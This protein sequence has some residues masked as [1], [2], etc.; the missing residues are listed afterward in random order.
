MTVTFPS[1]LAGLLSTVVALALMVGSGCRDPSSA[2]F[3]DPAGS[4]N[5]PKTQAVKTALGHV[6]TEEV[7]TENFAVAWPGDTRRPI[8]FRTAKPEQVA[9][10]A[11]KVGRAFTEDVGRKRSFMNCTGKGFELE[12]TLRKDLQA[13]LSV[14]EVEVK[15]KGAEVRLTKLGEASGQGQYLGLHY[16]GYTVA[17]EKDGENWKVVEVMLELT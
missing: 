15:E 10:S 4:S 9:P 2:S 3:S 5:S 8:N 14:E 17:L 6:L 12:C 1:R 16:A 13:I 7:S 11:E